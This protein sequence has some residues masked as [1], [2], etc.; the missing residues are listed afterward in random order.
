MFKPIFLAG[1]VI[2]S[3]A[4]FGCSVADRG[5]PTVAESPVQWGETVGGLQIGIAAET[6]AA[7]PGQP[8]PTQAPLQSVKIYLRND[9][10]VALMVMDPSAAPQLRTA[11]PT[12]A[13]VTIL[14]GSGAAEPQPSV[15]IPAPQTPR[16]VRLIPTQMTWFSVPVTLPAGKASASATTAAATASAWKIVAQYQNSQS[17]IAITPN[18]NSGP[19][20]TVSGVWTGQISSGDLQGNF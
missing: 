8:Q 17:V 14:Q 9:G 2:F 13:L 1:A 4:A 20:T 6:W 7:S 12:A 10:D 11:D 18:G 15:Y 3:L 19:V 16:F 5:T